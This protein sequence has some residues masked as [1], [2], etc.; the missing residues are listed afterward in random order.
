MDGFLIFAVLF[1]VTVDTFRPAM[2][3]RFHIQTG[4]I[5]MINMAMRTVGLLPFIGD[6]HYLAVSKVFFG[7]PLRRM[8]IITA[9]ENPAFFENRLVNRSHV[10]LMSRMAKG[11]GNQ[12]GIHPG[13]SMDTLLMP[14]MT[15]IADIGNIQGADFGFRIRWLPDAVFLV[16]TG[17]HRRFRI[18]RFQF[19]EMAGMNI[20][21]DIP[22]VTFRANI[23]DFLLVFDF[24]HHLPLRFEMGIM[25][26][27][28]NRVVACI[29]RIFLVM[30]TLP[31]LIGDFL[32][33][34]VADDF[35]AH[36]L[37]HVMNTMT[38][39]TV[40]DVRFALLL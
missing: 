31:I 39:F 15:L 4:K 12:R 13:G 34:S 14:G 20:R 21:F 7:M 25:A 26:G 1:S 24:G 3:H 37:L 29:L 33:A 5:P 38:A 2:F 40:R 36:V 35:H 17:T 9:I 10:G 22:L 28:A 18:A 23:H 27:G 30:I 32:M 11:A 6:F 8:A 19:V 16:A